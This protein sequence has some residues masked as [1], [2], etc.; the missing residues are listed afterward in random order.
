MLRFAG[1]IYRE[2]AEDQKTPQQ[3]VD[4]RF[5]E[6]T[7]ETIYTASLELLKRT[8]VQPEGAPIPAD[9]IEADGIDLIYQLKIPG[10]SNPVRL[11][12]DYASVDEKAVPRE[13]I[14]EMCNVGYAAIEPKT[15]IELLN[16]VATLQK[17]SPPSAMP[18]TNKEQAKARDWLEYHLPGI[19]VEMQKAIG[20]QQG[21]A[22]GGDIKVENKD[23]FQQ[24]LIQLLQGEAT[25]KAFT[26]A[27][28]AQKAAQLAKSLDTTQWQI[29][30]ATILATRGKAFPTRALVVQK[31]TELTQHEQYSGQVDIIGYDKDAVVVGVRIP[32]PME[33]LLFVFKRP[34]GT[35]DIQLVEAGL[36]L[37]GK[38]VLVAKADEALTK[39]MVTAM[40]DLTIA[41]DVAANPEYSQPPGAED[42]EGTQ[43]SLKELNKE[44]RRGLALWNSDSG[45]IKMVLKGGEDTGACYDEE[46]LMKQVTADESTLKNWLR[47]IRLNEGRVFW[48][49]PDG[50]VHL[51]NYGLQIIQRNIASIPEANRL[52]CSGPSK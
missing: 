30:I 36:S 27:E 6:G 51:M 45:Y 16:A 2:A 7:F 29:L 20:I 50:A 28:N 41:S 23:V 49:E 5:G 25:L 18:K 42:E 21:E 43:L 3:Q 19:L 32:P 37:C 11:T 35:N 17:L 13:A 52:Q 9:E 48:I 44:L 10:L 8:G 1:H 26:N 24:T 22:G 47:K 14:L 12:L 38:Q 40:V 4:E 15:L 31:I 46:E 33:D 34:P 39:L